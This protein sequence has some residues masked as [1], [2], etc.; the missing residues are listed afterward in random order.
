MG[1]Y[2]ARLLCA[3]HGQ[4]A[5]PISKHHHDGCAVAAG[6]AGFFL[7]WGVSTVILVVVYIMNERGYFK[8]GVGTLVS[9][10][11]PAKSVAGE[12]PWKPVTD[13]NGKTY[14]HNTATG[15]TSW[16]KPGGAAA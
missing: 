4:R 6:A 11:A 16:T 14:Y 12:S 13:P 8:K 3:T 5:N 7:G 1:R 10:L 9:T 15:E 2:A